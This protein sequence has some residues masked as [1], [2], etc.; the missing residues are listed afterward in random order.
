MHPSHILMVEVAG[1]GVREGSRAIRGPCVLVKLAHTP[2]RYYK[3]VQKLSVLLS[4][5]GGRDHHC[6]RESMVP[7]FFSFIIYYERDGF[8]ALLFC[9][10]RDVPRCVTYL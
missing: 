1:L 9:L 2:G 8:C 4:T 3:S 6:K 7:F 5:L 10:P